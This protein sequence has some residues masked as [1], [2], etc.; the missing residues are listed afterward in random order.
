MAESL[1]IF[2]IGGHVINDA[3]ELKAFLNDFAGI[4]GNKMLVHGGGRWVSDMSRRLG[5][6]VIMKEGRRITD[7][8]TLEVVKMMLPGVANKNIVATLQSFGCNALGLTGADGNLIRAD[9]RPVRDNIDY[10]YVGDVK[11]V[12]GKKIGQILDLGFIPVFTAMTHDGRGQLLNTN[13]DTIASTLAVEMSAYYEVDLFYCFEKPGVMSDLNDELSV[14]RVITPSAYET[15][16]AG[17]AI[18]SGMI[19][20]I[21]NAFDALDRGVARI[22][23]CPYRDI[24][25]LTDPDSEIGTLIIRN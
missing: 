2:K 14:I 23:I 18:H 6:E 9:R 19:P 22:H 16:K 7:A 4:P 3:G 12:E 8:D 17:G 1:S 5:L 20:K 25:K 24:G 10:G 11:K 13:A 21:D 15:Y